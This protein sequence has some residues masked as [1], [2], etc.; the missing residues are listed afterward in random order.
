MTDHLIVV[1]GAG[2]DR[3]KLKRPKMGAI[4]ARYAQLFVLTSDNPRSEDPA[5][6][7]R[8]IM[9]GIAPDLHG[10]VIRELDRT[11]AIGKAYSLSHPGSIIAI[12]GRGPEEYQTIAT[13]KIRLVDAEVVQSLR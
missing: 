4:A 5:T 9:D 12:L 8:D 1:L 7:A 2:G 3:D 11:K 13:G 10:K 6:I